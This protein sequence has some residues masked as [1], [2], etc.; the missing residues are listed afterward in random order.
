[1]KLTGAQILCET[2]EHLGVRDIFGYPGGAILPVYDA[3]G[4]SKLHHVLVR[5]EQGATHMADGYARASG[6]IGVAIATSGPGATNMVT[7][8]A[9]AMLDSSPVV[10][11]TGQVGSKLLGSDAFQEVDITGITMPITKHNVVVSKVEDIARTVREAFIIANSGRPGPVLVD[12]TK[13]AQQATREFDWETCGPK[14]PTK[15]IRHNHN[16]EEF[17]RASSF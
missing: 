14:L 2:L 3:I 11:I 4:K 15:R 1:M 5:H 8:I 10:C 16:Q 9:T 17:D 13:D 6:G 12:I 7:G